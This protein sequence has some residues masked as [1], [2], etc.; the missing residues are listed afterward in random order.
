MK[1]MKL[2]SKKVYIVHRKEDG[3]EY[4]YIFGYDKIFSL[5]GKVY[6]KTSPSLFYSITHG[7]IRCFNKKDCF[8]T[9]TEAK[10][11][12]AESEG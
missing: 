6:V 2:I 3:Y 7:G 9:V 1:I 11:Y 8:K 10:A 12:I 4:T 5:F